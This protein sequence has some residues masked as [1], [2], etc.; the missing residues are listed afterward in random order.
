MSC[1]S[2]QSHRANDDVD[3]LDADERH[4][5]AAEAVDQQVAAQQRRGADRPDT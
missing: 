3:D 1:S 5:H 4:D 2:R